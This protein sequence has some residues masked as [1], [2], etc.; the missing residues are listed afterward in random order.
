MLDGFKGAFR[1]P[2]IPGMSGRELPKAQWLRRLHVTVIEGFD[3]GTLWFE[4]DAGVLIPPAE[5]RPCIGGH[6]YTFGPLW[7]GG[8]WCLV[9]DFSHATVGLILLDFILD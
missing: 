9:T 2:V 5:T 6:T 3:A 8:H 4:T 1:I 7:I